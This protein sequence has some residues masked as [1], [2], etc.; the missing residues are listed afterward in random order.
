MRSKS[1]SFGSSRDRRPSN[2][3]FRRWRF[4]R[5]HQFMMIDRLLRSLHYHWWS[6]KELR[7]LLVEWLRHSDVLR[8]WS[9]EIFNRI[10]YF[11]R[12]NLLWRLWNLGFGS[13]RSLVKIIILGFCF[14]L[15]WVVLSCAS[16]TIFKLRLCLF[17]LFF[18]Y[19]LLEL[20][21]VE[22][23][24]L[25]I[26]SILNQL[27]ESI[28]TIR[29]NVLVIDILFMMTYSITLVL[30]FC[31]YLID[32]FLFPS[33]QQLVINVFFRIK[34]IIFLRTNIIKS[35]I[36]LLLIVIFHHLHYFK[37]ISRHFP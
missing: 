25:D 5:S 36:F 17:V 30:I 18:I 29:I 15:Y 33:T 28:K 3:H 11:L 23:L 24:R 32:T 26:V 4:S 31:L 34:I 7:K 35:L 1:G 13:R 21:K 2:N 9:W 27:I 10:V 37:M 6:M 14:N 16:E 19:F 22:R 12:I 20:V 8:T